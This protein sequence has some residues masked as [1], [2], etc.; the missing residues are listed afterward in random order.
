MSLPV[1]ILSGYLGAGKTTLVNQMLRQA[2]GKR[3]AI[4]VNEFGDLP[5]DADLIEAEGDDMIALAG[6]CVCCS[7]GDDLMAALTQMAAMQ[8]PPD[9]IIL[10]A[11][12]VA[13]P[14]AIASS[15][16]IVAGIRA[17]GV[18]VLADVA[19]IEG[20]LA[21]DYIG[22]T[23][24][25]QLAAADLV[26]LTKGDIAGAAQVAHA[27]TTVAAHADSAAVVEA[28]H[29]RVPLDVVL[30]PVQIAIPQRGEPH[31][32]AAGLISEVDVPEG[33]VDADDYARELA[34]RTE[35]IRAKGHVNTAQ[36][37]RTVQVVGSQWEVSAPPQNAQAGV[38][39][40]R[41]KDPV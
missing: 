3:L 17:A 40:I 8:P 4:M 33:E 39:V 20:Q 5:I 22:D 24:V 37:L 1:T 18:V 36:G 19:Q 28:S 6:G 7:Y 21:N 13:L 2:D 16:G 29:G 32:N 38:V 31:G 27:R 12:G 23:V 35:V 26:V 14:G 30:N 15:L 11:S 10:E 25:R 41:L 34:S 9:H